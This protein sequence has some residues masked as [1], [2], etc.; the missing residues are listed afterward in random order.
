MDKEI[1]KSE[2]KAY[3][4]NYIFDGIILALLGIVML[5]WPGQALKV[6]CVVAGGSL[7]VMGFIKL[8]FFLMAPKEEKK[9]SSLIISIVQLAAG[10]ALILASDLFVSVFFVITGLILAYGAFMM[11]VRAIQLRRIKGVMFIM[12]LAFA[13]ISL[14]F[15]VIIFINPAAFAS[16]LM[17][18]QGASLVIEGI[19]MIIVLRNMEFTLK[20]S[21]ESVI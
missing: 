15:A 21:E 18:I 12:S 3:F 2:K 20:V 4:R 7:A 8:A 5:I 14:A 6:L 1:I 11:F 10:L 9:A 19:G 16:M 13:V 17:R